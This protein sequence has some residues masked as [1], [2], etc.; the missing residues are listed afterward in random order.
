MPCRVRPIA[1]WYDGSVKW[2]LVDAQVDL[3]PDGELRLRLLPG[4]PAAASKR[5]VT[6]QSTADSLLV[7]T[8]AARFQFPRN[9]FGLPGAAWVEAEVAW[10]EEWEVE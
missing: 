1:H 2:L 5:P 4:K 7:D 3:Q 10:E 9:R 8:G 6:V